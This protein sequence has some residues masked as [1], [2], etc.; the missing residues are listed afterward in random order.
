MAEDLDYQALESLVATRTGWTPPN[1]LPEKLYHYTSS[2]AFLSIVQ[3]NTLWFTDFRYM[4]DLSELRYGVDLVRAAL[5][6]RF[7]GPKDQDILRIEPWALEQLEQ[8][9]VY[10]EVFVFCMCEEDNLLNQWRVYGKDTVPVSIGYPV[11]TFQQE[12][13]SYKLTILPMLY[14]EAVQRRIID[15]CVDV[16]LQHAKTHRATLRTDEDIKSFVEIWISICVDWCTQLKHPQFA[17]EKEWRLAIRWGLEHRTFQARH[18][19]SS[20]GGIVPY[21]KIRPTD[22]ALDMCSVTIGPCRYPEIQRRTMHE[23]LYQHHQAQAE[24]HMSNLPIRV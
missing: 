15:A 10:T 19:R 7:D 9:L 12:F 21:L 13:D 18:F 23:F 1:Q 14:D 5:R 24:V 20:P 3:N 17:V 8:A 22:G 16:G 11:K 4:N 6:K 2:E